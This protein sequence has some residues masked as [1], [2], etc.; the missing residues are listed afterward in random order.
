MHSLLIFGNY[1]WAPECSPLLLDSGTL[2]L[3]CFLLLLL[4]L[5]CC[6]KDPEVDVLSQDK[7]A[8]F[9]L[10]SQLTLGGGQR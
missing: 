2:P 6:Y 5:V 3:L 10:S 8:V 4:F 7:S 1:P 9:L